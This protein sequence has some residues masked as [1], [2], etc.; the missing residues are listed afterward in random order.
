MSP[1]NHL[2]MERSFSQYVLQDAHHFAITIKGKRGALVSQEERERECV[3]EEGREGGQDG[4]V[5]EDER[6]RWGNGRKNR[7][8]KHY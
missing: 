8:L 7:L 4:R 2:F 6:T 5:I 1:V 3:C